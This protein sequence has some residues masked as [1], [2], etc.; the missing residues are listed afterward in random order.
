MKQVLV[1]KVTVHLGFLCLY[2]ALR[3]QAEIPKLALNWLIGN[4][5]VSYLEAEKYGALCKLIALLRSTFF[6]LDLLHSQ[7]PSGE[8]LLR[9]IKGAMLTI[10]CA[11]RK[12]GSWQNLSRTSLRLD[13]KLVLTWDSLL[14]VKLC[15][16]ATELEPKNTAL[17]TFWIFGWGFF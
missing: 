8:Q 7:N 11:W 14:K 3:C 16:L 10:L 1:E 6:W 17:V 9:V 2:R 5:L 4:Q 12:G 13:P 15:Q